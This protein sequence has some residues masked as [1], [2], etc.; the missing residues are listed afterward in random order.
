[1]KDNKKYRNELKQ[2]RK[3][4]KEQERINENNSKHL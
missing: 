2:K 3:E 4:L 1:M